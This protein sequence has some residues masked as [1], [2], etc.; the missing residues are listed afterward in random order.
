MYPLNKGYFEKEPGI[1]SSWPLRRR[2][3]SYPKGLDY[4]STELGAVAFCS[5]NMANPN[6]TLNQGLP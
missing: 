4:C 2:D 6:P 5:E 1:L 3:R